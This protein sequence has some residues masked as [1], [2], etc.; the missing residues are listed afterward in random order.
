MAFVIL[1]HV[2]QVT[3]HCQFKGWGLHLVGPVGGVGDNHWLWQGSTTAECKGWCLFCLLQPHDLMTAAP[4]PW[5]AGAQLSL[6]FSPWG[7]PYPRR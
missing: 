4:F 3:Q 1:I 2:L 5:M 6:L 7:K